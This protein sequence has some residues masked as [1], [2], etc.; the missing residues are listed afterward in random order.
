MK[1]FHKM[2]IELDT[3]W[4]W[5]NG[6][7]LISINLHRKK[8][9]RKRHLACKKHR[10]VVPWLNFVFWVWFIKY[11]YPTCNSC[12][13][14]QVQLDAL[15]ISVLSLHEVLFQIPTLHMFW[16]LLLF[17]MVLTHLLISFGLLHQ[18]EGLHRHC[19][20]HLAL[21]GMPS[22]FDWPEG[23]CYHQSFVLV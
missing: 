18:Q 4:I 3:S 20:F 2:P 16:A 7:S 22:W 21:W 9:I 23:H 19:E 8:S 12:C 13:L 10:T 15:F 14:H 1:I 5:S 6:P 17:L 11:N